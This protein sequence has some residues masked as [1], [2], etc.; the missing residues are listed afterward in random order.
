M[1]R[2]KNGAPV[3]FLVLSM[4]AITVAIGYAQPETLRLVDANPAVE[5][6]TWEPALVDAAGEALAPSPVCEGEFCDWCEDHWFWTEHQHCEQGEEL[7]NAQ[8][9]SFCVWLADT[10]AGSGHDACD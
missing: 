5:F 2:A 7:E 9:H 6:S 3:A 4:L 10:C 8:N 1:I